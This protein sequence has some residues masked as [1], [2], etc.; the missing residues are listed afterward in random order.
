MFLLQS[1]LIFRYFVFM[2]RVAQGINLIQ[3]FLSFPFQFLF[4]CSKPGPIDSHNFYPPFTLFFAV[5]GNQNLQ[6]IGVHN[7]NPENEHVTVDKI[8]HKE[9]LFVAAAKGWSRQ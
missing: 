5:F 3:S 1:H 7:S 4:C 8:Q 2:A 6:M 9:V